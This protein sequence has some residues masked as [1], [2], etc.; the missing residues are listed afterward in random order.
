MAFVDLSGRPL[1]QVKAI[2][3]RGSKLQRLRP[4]RGAFFGGAAPIDQP[5]QSGA[6]E[7]AFTGFGLAA[8]QPVAVTLAD[9]P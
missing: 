7:V 2:V 1:R 9:A 4:D 6:I 8:R 3:L 5:V